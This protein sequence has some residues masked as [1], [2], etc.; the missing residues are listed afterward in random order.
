MPVTSV[1]KG[2]IGAPGE[3]LNAGLRAMHGWNLSPGIEADAFYPKG[4][5]I[6]TLFKLVESMTKPQGRFPSAFL[7][8]AD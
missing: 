4:S 1:R 8:R 6:R 5:N 7:D 3:T 2:V